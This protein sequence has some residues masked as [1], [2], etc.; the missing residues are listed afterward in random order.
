MEQTTSIKVILD[1]LLRNPLLSDLSFEAAVDY[2]VDFYRLVGIPQM[3]IEKV[4]DIPITS[5]KGVLPDDWVDTISIGYMASNDL[6]THNARIIPMRY[7]TSTFTQ[8][9]NSNEQII[10]H[11]FMIQNSII[12]CSAETCTVRLS[13]RAIAVDNDGYPLILDNSAFTRALGSYIK[14]QHYTI[15]FELGKISQVIY[16]QLKQDYAFAVGACSTDLLRLDLPK[17]ESFYNMYSTLLVR[18][19]EY[20]NKFQNTGS[21]EFLIRH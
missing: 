19:N 17:A 2:T 13:Y 20:N 4:V 12:V 8:S 10:E 9:P 6:V 1:K 15:L 21:K 7:S 3:F 18:S 5:Y 16:Q 14:V 11:T